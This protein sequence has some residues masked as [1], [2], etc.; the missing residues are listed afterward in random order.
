MADAIEDLLSRIRAAVDRY[1]MIQPGDHIG[2]GVS[3]GKDSVLLLAALARLERFYPAPFTLTA[4]TLDPGFG[5]EMTDYSPLTALCEQWGIEHIVRRTELW[6]IVFEQ[7]KESNP[8]SLCA[9]MR[10]GILHKTALE[11]GC[12][13]IALGHHQDD[14][15]ETLMMN[16]LSGGTIDCFSPKSYLS[17]REL[18][19]IRP[20][21]FLSEKEIASAVARSHLPVVK[22]R[23]PVDGKTNRQQTRELLACLSEQYG[24]L[25][26]RLT[27]ALQKGSISGW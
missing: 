9:R 3:G 25:N 5:G 22:S 14:A 15:A 10:R 12:N 18:W 4:I 7:R 8:C 13:S 23:C 1:D 2:I 17:R 27:G 20:L 24:P 26:E 6:K 19:M 11:V 16:L 21:I